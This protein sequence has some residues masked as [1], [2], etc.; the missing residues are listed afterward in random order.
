MYVRLWIKERESITQ[1]A[2]VVMQAGRACAGRGGGERTIFLPS[3][4]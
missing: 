3:W 1:G 4:R 2:R